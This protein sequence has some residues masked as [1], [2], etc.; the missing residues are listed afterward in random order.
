MSGD[1]GARKRKSSS[2]RRC[3]DYERTDTF[4]VKGRVAATNGDQEEPCVRI[5]R[6]THLGGLAFEPLQRLPRGRR[7]QLEV[8]V[9]MKHGQPRDF[10]GRS[11]E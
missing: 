10:C 4:E 1:P 2:D 11:D 3:R 6:R 7:D 9:A 5:L 8:L